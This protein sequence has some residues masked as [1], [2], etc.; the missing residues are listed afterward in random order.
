MLKKFSFLLLLSSLFAS[1]SLIAQIGSNQV[2]GQVDGS[3]PIITAVPFLN[4]GPDSRGSG[5]GDVGVAT[6][7]DANS[8]FWNPSKLAFVEKDMGAAFSVTPWLK[9]IVGDMN[10]YYLSGYKK[11]NANSTF[12]A[13]M[14]YFDL[15]SMQFTD[16]NRNIIA[17]FNPREFSFDA[18]YAMKLSQKFGMGVTMRYIYSNLSGNFSNGQSNTDAKPA[19]S[20][21]ADISGFYTT[22]LVIKGYD[23]KLSFGANISNIGPKITYTSD[24]NK[25]FIPTNLRIGTALTTEFDPYNKLTFAFDVNKLLVPTPPIYGE[26]EDGNPVVVKGK[27]SSDKGMLAGMFISFADAPG[28]AKEEF[29]ELMFGTGLEYWYNDLVA[30]RG[31]YFH[32]AR[33]KG[34]RQYFT[35]G[36]GLRYQVFGIDFSYLISKQQNHPLTDTMRFTLSFNMDSKKEEAKL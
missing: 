8:A 6:S 3:N 12:S 10:L 1:T 24:N 19:N 11:I 23:S 20:L 26:D 17:D 29:Q 13:S 33:T 30:V 2:G 31:G 28:G 35:V 27:D 36:V 34:N 9:Q 15:G 7:P 16:I 32:E 5:M 22:D 25:D 21:A 14:R 18:T 4:I